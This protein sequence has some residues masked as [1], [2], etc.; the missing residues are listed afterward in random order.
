MAK[1]PVVS[2]IIVNFNAGNLLKQCLI[3]IYKQTFTD[4]EIIIVDNASADDSLKE[5]Q[6]GRS[7][8]IIHNDHNLGF[9]SAQNQGM[10]I[11]RGCYLM[12]LNFD[13]AL[14]PTFL[15]EMVSALETSDRVGAVS[16][17]LLRLNPDGS[18]TKQIDNA[19]LLLPRNRFPL[20]RGANEIDNGQFDEPVLVFGAMGAAALYR[21]DMLEDVAY[22]GQFFDE[23][24][25]MW[26][27][28]IDLDWRSR[29]LGWDCLYTPR[30][31]AYHIR[32]VH[33]HGHSRFGAE[34]SIRNRWLAI[35]ANECARCFF[36]NAPWLVAEEIALFRYVVQRG[37]LSVYRRALIEFIRKLPEA[38]KKR[39]YVR[40]RVKRMC[41]PDYPISISI[42]L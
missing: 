4:Y 7:V 14:C 29:L 42:Y 18:P 36:M 9:A 25:F 32:D 5:I 37:W 24:Y 16:G 26:Y 28:D 20:H 27:E 30:A 11:A 19:G 8:T 23:S 41:L 3:T 17:K 34:V 12:P 1:S 13:V 31:V 6:D 39:L 38:I 35:V 2:I 33:G 22:L 15:H 10:G 21:R 40:G